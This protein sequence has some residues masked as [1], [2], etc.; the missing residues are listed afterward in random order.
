MPLAIPPLP[1]RSEEMLTTAAIIAAKKT[2]KR[3]FFAP[4]QPVV[5]FLTLSLTHYKTGRKTPVYRIFQAKHDPM[6]AG[7]PPGIDTAI[8][9]YL[10]QVNSG[11]D[12]L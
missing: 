11:R 2:G 6:D 12:C 1:K 7:A 4:R 3:C 9:W 8:T 10:H 5:A